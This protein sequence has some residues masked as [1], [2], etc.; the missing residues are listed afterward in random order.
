M[1]PPILSLKNERKPRQDENA[2]L[3]CH[4][5]TLP[6]RAC[7]GKGVSQIATPGGTLPARAEIGEDY[8]VTDIFV[9]I[10]PRACGKSSWNHLALKAIWILPARGTARKRFN[11]NRK[12]IIEDVDYFVRISDALR[13]CLF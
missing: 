9:H 6:S 12:H 2:I 4:S 10:H 13:P 1:R 11:D 8:A 7:G 3:R 5:F